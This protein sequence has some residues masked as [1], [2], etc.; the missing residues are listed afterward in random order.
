VIRLSIGASLSWVLVV[1]NG[2]PLKLQPG[3]S[4]ACT[5]ALNYFS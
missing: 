2:L 5:I 4:T 1:F 3:T